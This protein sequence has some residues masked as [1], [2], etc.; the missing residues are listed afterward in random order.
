MSPEETKELLRLK[1]QRRLASKEEDDEDAGGGIGGF[2]RRTWVLF[3][4]M[5][6]LIYGYNVRSAQSMKG[7]GISKY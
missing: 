6:G 5:G 1:E 4:V 2:K 3:S 7:C